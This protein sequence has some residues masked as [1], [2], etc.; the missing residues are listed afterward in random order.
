[1]VIISFHL[2]ETDLVLGLEEYEPVKGVLFTGTP[3]PNGLK[4][5]ENYKFEEEGIPKS[6]DDG[7][8]SGLF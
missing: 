1:L 3:K 8:K 5:D 4:R 2:V 7:P 6:K